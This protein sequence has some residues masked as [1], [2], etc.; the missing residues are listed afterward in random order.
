VG[1]EARGRCWDEIRSSPATWYR[2]RLTSSHTAPPPDGFGALLRFFLAI[3]QRGII[4]LESS[5]RRLVAGGGKSLR[6]RTKCLVANMHQHAPALPLADHKQG[7]ELG[8]PFGLWYPSRSISSPVALARPCQAFPPA[9]AQGSVRLVRGPS[10][11]VLFHRFARRNSPS[12]PQPS[13]I[14]YSTLVASRQRNPRSSR[15]GID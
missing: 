12:L 13:S 4:Q 2:N 3:G 8:K 7:L 14:P 11:Y 6:K 5:G 9:N 1:V 15:Q 10:Q